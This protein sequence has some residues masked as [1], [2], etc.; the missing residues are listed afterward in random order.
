MSWLGCKKRAQGS[1]RNKCANRPPTSHPP[2][3]Q[4]LGSA[5]GL[6]WLFLCRGKQGQQK[7]NKVWILEMVKKKTQSRF[8]GENEDAKMYLKKSLPLIALLHLTFAL[9]FR[10]LNR[11]IL[12]WCQQG[13]FLQQGE[14]QKS[15]S[16]KKHTGSWLFISL[17]RKLPINN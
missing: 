9:D 6:G 15:N 2:S 16:A 4:A 1:P 11:L 17:C 8:N 13:N 7:K 5:E 3:A 10:I 12:D 14:G